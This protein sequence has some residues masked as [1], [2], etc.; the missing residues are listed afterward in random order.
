MLHLPEKVTIIEV[1]PRDGLQNEKLFVPTD[2]KKQF[3]AGLRKAGL[4]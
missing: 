2:T 4:K 3:I 1:G